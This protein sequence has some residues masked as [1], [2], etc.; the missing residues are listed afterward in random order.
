MR[1]LCWLP[2]AS[3]G[4]TIP[5][6]FQKC[7]QLSLLG[8]SI[9]RTSKR[10]SLW[11]STPTSSSPPVTASS[12][13]QASRRGTRDWELLAVMKR[14]PGMLIFS[15]LFST[16]GR[17]RRLGKRGREREVLAISA[18]DNFPF[19]F[20]EYVNDIKGDKNKF[21]LTMKKIASRTIIAKGNKFFARS[22]KS[23]LADYV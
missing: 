9:W 22:C 15:R 19:C 3:S 18:E 4:F 7:L 21:S 12:P 13:L 16:W 10:E 6:L 8:R 11:W 17:K 20:S 5:T 2:F 23:Q 1:I 14:N